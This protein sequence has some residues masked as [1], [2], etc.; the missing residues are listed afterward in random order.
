[1]RTIAKACDYCRQAQLHMPVSRTIHGVNETG[2]VDYSS[3]AIID[4]HNVT[5]GLQCTTI[6]EKGEESSSPTQK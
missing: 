3:K 2:E 5:S 1:M 4:N 6:T